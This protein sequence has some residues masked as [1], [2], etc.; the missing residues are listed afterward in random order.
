MP[1]KVFLGMLGLL[2]F[3]AFDAT[4]DSGD[5]SP[6]DPPTLPKPPTESEAL[7]AEGIEALRTERSARRLAESKIRDLENSL[8]DLAEKLQKRE[9]DDAEK[10]GQWEKLAES[11]AVKI[12]ELEKSIEEDRLKKE[13]AEI[14]AKYKLVEAEAMN[15]HGETIEQFEESAK[16]QAK[17]LGKNSG[18]NVNGGEGEHKPT[19]ST[20]KTSK[21]S[22]WKFN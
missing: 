14:L 10:Q 3:S 15:V 1:L 13:Q 21:L 12:V 20:S 11:R 2:A 9:D 6:D 16:L 4:G 18:P 22:N 19:P 7:G 8:K 17:L 5:D